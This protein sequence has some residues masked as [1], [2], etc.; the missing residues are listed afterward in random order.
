M[1]IRLFFTKWYSHKHYCCSICSS[2]TS[3]TTVFIESR[4][5]N[6]EFE[7]PIRRE[8]HYSLPYISGAQAFLL[9]AV[10]W[11]GSHLRIMDLKWNG[12]PEP[13]EGNTLTPP[14][15]PSSWNTRV[16]CTETSWRHLDNWS[17]SKR[18]LTCCGADKQSS[19]MNQV[20]SGVPT[21]TSKMYDEAVVV[22]EEGIVVTTAATD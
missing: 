16:I 20:F 4:E 9:F 2:F 15:P 12:N 19:K 14:I 21:E 18:W 8:R 7:V 22:T 13:A 11:P 5:N 17:T 1:S 6:K 10:H 3:W